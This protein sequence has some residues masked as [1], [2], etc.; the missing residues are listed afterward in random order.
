[1]KH[2]NHFLDKQSILFRENVWRDKERHSSEMLIKT[3]NKNLPCHGEAFGKE[4]TESDHHRDKRDVVR[5]T[6]PP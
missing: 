3:S 1:M 5:S 6:G 4:K 2:P